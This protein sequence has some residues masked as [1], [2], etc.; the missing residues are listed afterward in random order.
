MTDEPTTAD[1]PGHHS[2][3]QPPRRGL[4]ITVTLS[5]GGTVRLIGRDLAPSDM[6]EMLQMVEQ[7]LNDTGIA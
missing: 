5:G 6:H 1:Q 2:A 4:D 7:G 3:E